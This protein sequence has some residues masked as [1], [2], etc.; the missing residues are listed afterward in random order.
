MPIQ[1]FDFEHLVKVI[2]VICR[3]YWFRYLRFYY[4]LC[5]WIISIWGYHLHISQCFGAVTIY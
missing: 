3:V 1:S 5:W 2:P 4:Y